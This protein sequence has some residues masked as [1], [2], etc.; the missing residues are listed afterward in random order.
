MISTEA[1]IGYVLFILS[2][3]VS[4]IPIPANGLLHSFMIGI[5]NSFKNQNTNIEIAQNLLNKNPSLANLINKLNSNANIGSSINRL[6]ENPENIKLID[7]I[8]NDNKLQYIITLL[9][10]NPN[11]I[12]TVTNT[13]ERQIVLQKKINISQSEDTHITQEDTRI[14]QEDT[15]INV[16]SDPIISS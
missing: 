4:I 13:V 10:N 5:Q 9:N 12:N 14:K 1:I 8:S 16:I 15:V 3:L 11:I 7:L 2:E 6:L